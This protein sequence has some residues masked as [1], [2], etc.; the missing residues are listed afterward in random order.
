MA[1]LPNTR[2]TQV[3]DRLIGPCTL[4]TLV[5]REE[6][7][8]AVAQRTRA[9]YVRRFVLFLALC[10]ATYYVTVAITEAAHMLA[11]HP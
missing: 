7:P 6:R 10:A 4:Q 11:A 5:A 1:R 8:V 3:L 2:T 9:Q